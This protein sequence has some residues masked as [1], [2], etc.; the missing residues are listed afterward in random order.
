MR[1]DDTVKKENTYGA[2][3]ERGEILSASADTY[4]VLSL[5]RDGIVS[6]PTTAVGL[7]T[8]AVGDLV[9]FFVFADGTRRILSKADRSAKVVPDGAITPEKI[10]DNFITGLT[11]NASGDDT[12]LL[13][14]GNRGTS[15][16]RKFTFASLAA[17]IRDKLASLTFSALNTSSKTLPGA[18][19]EL[20]NN[21]TMVNSVL[22]DSISLTAGVHQNVVVSYTAPSGYVISGAS[23]MYTPNAAWVFANVQSVGSSAITLGTYNSATVTVTGK[24]QLLIFLRKA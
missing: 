2:V 9:Y 1:E 22:S 10:S 19:N 17:Y 7:E 24:F 18:I 16:L 8:Y 5:D 20:N 21:K 14:V 15:A 3:V 11:E 13:V 23:I 12:D 4:T 6:L